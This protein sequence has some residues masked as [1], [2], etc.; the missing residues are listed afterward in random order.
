MQMKLP[1]DNIADPELEAPDS[2]F[3]DPTEAPEGY[4]A[5]PKSRFAGGENICRYCHWRKQ[6]NDPRTDLLAPGHRCMGYSV[7]AYVDGKRHRR[8]DR[9]SV[10]FRLPNPTDG[11]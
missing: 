7:T 1:F 6:C 4:V 9:C 2:D 3:C 8:K 5:V 11:S 10:V